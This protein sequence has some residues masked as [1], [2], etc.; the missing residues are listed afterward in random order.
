MSD[1]TIHDV[2]AATLAELQRRAQQ[3]SRSVDAEIVAIVEEVLLRAKYARLTKE[4]GLVSALQE[5]SREF[6][7]TDEFD[8]LRD[9]GKG[10]PPAP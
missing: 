4:Q 7:I 3:N 6:S 10:A 2:S 8:H 1:I 9:P 5:L